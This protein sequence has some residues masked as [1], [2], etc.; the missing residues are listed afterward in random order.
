MPKMPKAAADL[1]QQWIIEQLRFDRAEHNAA[2]SESLDWEQVIS[3]AQQNGLAGLLLA[4]AASHTL[5]PNVR[6]R[7]EAIAFDTRTYNAAHRLGL[8][9]WLGRFDAAGISTVILKGIAVTA[10]VYGR[11]ALR[12]MQDVDVLVRR[13]DFERAGELLRAA[14]FTRY[15]ELGG[16]TESTLRTQS[17]WIHLTPPGIALDLHWHVID[18]GY[19]AHHVPIEWF[20]DHTQSVPLLARQMRVLTPEAQLLHLAA[21]LEL[22]HA[23][24]GLL[25]LYDVAALIHKLGGTMDW[26]LVLATATRFEWGQSLRRTVQ[27]AQDVF[28]VS[29]PNAVRDRLAHLPTTWHERL[30]RALATPAAHPA[31]F[32]FDGWWQPG[33]RGKVRYWWR[34]LFPSAEFMQVHGPVRSD[35]ELAWQYALRL[36]RGVQRIPRALWAGITQMHQRRDGY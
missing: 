36:G 33:V 1:A 17:H 6:A 35:G 7:L 3:T 27:R 32:V 24:G 2:L 11:S 14:G 31:V 19:Y 23:G 18:S 34:S 9:E 12:R 21:H 10:L 30:V 8:E 20:W 22:H 4:S 13:A 29:I 26:D 28:G 5:P 16:T 15:R 25:A